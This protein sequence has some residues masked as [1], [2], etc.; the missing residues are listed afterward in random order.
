MITPIK[1]LVVLMMGNRSFDH[2]LGYLQA[3]N[4]GIKGVDGT[5]NNPGTAGTSVYVS[6]NAS[7]CGRSV[8]RSGARIR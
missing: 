6:S 5:Q 7:L 1:H 3:P 4:P 8:P 2:M